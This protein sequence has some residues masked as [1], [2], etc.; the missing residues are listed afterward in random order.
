MGGS[1]ENWLD[2]VDAQ[3]AEAER[4]PAEALPGYQRAM[5]ADDL[6]AAVRGTAHVGAA[7]CL[8]ALGRR[9]EA[10]ALLEPATRLL[11][12]WGGWRVAELVELRDQFGA[13]EQPAGGDSQ[14]TPRELEVAH[15][16]AEGLTNAELARRLFISPRT[17]AV[18]VSNILSKL[19]VSSRTQVA[20]RLNSG[21]RGTS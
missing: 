10:A 12:R 13:R 5:L 20:Q 19:G 9:E 14:L 4:H 2:L 17:A 6:P 11:E 21:A 8:L 7:R 15:L 18:H 16:L 1:A 3:L